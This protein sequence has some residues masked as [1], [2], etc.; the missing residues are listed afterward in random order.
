MRNTALFKRPGSQTGIVDNA[1]LPVLLLAFAMAFWFGFQLF[2]TL[3]T[4]D[5]LANAWNS[6]EPQ[7]QAADKVKATLTALATGTKQLASQGNPNAAQIVY[8]LAQRGINIADPKPPSP[9]LMQP[10]LQIQPQ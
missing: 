5:A 7:V 3:K 2:Q 6:Q 10:E 1:L 8:A 4:R 9:P